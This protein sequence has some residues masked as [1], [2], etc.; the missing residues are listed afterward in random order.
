[1]QPQLS[2]VMRGM[3]GVPQL[4]FNDDTNQL[5]IMGRTRGGGLVM[6]SMSPAPSGNPR[7]SRRSLVS[8]R[9]MRQLTRR[10]GPVTDVTLAATDFDSDGEL[11]DRM[12]QILFNNGLVQQMMLADNGSVRSMRINQP[13]DNQPQVIM[14][15]LG[16]AM[17]PSG[18]M[19][20]DVSTDPSRRNRS[21][22]VAVG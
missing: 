9:D 16:L 12:V 15:A 2:N 4:E 22:I 6:A 1:M 11:D 8:D 3:A 20:W 13:S 5:M 18:D 21:R 17:T 19:V 14:S 10:N 7:I